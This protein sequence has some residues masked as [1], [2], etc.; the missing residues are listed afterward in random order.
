MKECVELEEM[1]G[2]VVVQNLLQG[3]DVDFRSM[4]KVIMQKDRNMPIQKCKEKATLIAEVV[5]NKMAQNL[6]WSSGTRWKVHCQ[7]ASPHYRLI[8]HHGRGRRPCPFCEDS[9]F[10]VTIL[11]HVLESHSSRWDYMREFLLP[12]LLMLYVLICFHMSGVSTV[13]CTS[14]FTIIMFYSGSMSTTFCY[15]LCMYTTF[16]CILSC[17]LG[18]NVPRLR[19]S[20]NFEPFVIASSLLEPIYARTLTPVAYLYTS[21]RVRRHSVEQ[22]ASMRIHEDIYNLKGIGGNTIRILHIAFSL[23]CTD[24]THETVPSVYDIVYIGES[25]PCT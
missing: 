4:K 9:D 19:R 3:E 22:E 20:I 24:T 12:L 1:F 5:E 2:C 8:S 15:L 18:C 16:C 6:G 25:I 14:N 7:V 23:K 11:E 13:Y 21:R 17:C 10:D